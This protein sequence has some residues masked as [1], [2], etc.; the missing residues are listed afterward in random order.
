M[1]YWDKE[2]AKRKVEE[3]SKDSLERLEKDCTE[4]LGALE[5]SFR[6]RMNAENKRFR[7]MCDTEYWFAVC[8]SSREQKDEFLEKIGLDTSG[9]Y[10]D[11]KAL[12]M[13][14]RRSIRTPDLEFAGIRPYDKDYIARSKDFE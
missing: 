2:D 6:D 5:A 13:A 9:K 14:F 4:E 1:G 10:I 3:D 8:F 12:A 11:G 7:D